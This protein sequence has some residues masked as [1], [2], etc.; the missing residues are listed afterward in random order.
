MHISVLLKEA[1]EMMNLK[2]GQIVVDAT[3]GGGGH[4]EKI[5]EKIG[6]EGKI[7]AIDLD[8]KAIEE[9]KNKFSDHKDQI[10]FVNDNFA[11]VGKALEKIKIKKVD[12]ILADLGWRMDQV[13]KAEYG[14]SFRKEGPLDM[15]MNASSSQGMTAEKII[16]DWDEKDLVEIF[17]K[18]G[19]EKHSGLVAKSI[20][21]TRKKK[22]I[23]TTSELSEILEKSLGR[24]YRNKKIH[25]ATKVFQALR[26][27]VNQ[28][29]EN[30]EKFLPQALN[31]LKIGGYL[32]VIAFNSLEDR[33]VKKFF[34]ANARGCI[35][36]KEFPI[37]NCGQKPKLKIV[38]LK[39]IIPGE[40]ELKNNPRSRSAKLRVIQKI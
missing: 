19:E 35:C 24:Y 9:N 12:A 18:Y 21:A 8:E 17:K 2:E 29:L 5:L 31:G 33:I 30:L 14:I 28:E 6:A 40:K 39:P 10:Y 22:E 7:I 25:P 26:I 36:P 16:N 3:L 13:E 20:V 4:A 23:K 32:A 27:T 34:Q 1:V 15:R 37:C 11:N 38:T